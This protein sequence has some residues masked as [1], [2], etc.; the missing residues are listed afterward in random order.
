MRLVDTGFESQGFVFH[1]QLLPREW[2]QALLV[3]LATC[4]NLKPHGDR[5]LT[6]KVPLVAELCCDPSLLGGVQRYLQG[7][8]RLVR[9]LYFN[10]TP[11]TNWGIRWHQDK[12]IAL[13]HRCE[14]PG[15]G[16][17]SRKDGVDHVQP[18]L[19]VLERM[20]TLR[21]HLDATD[22]DQGCLQVIPGSHRDGILSPDAIATW[23]IRGPIQACDA[24]VGDGLLMRPHLLHA[25][26]RATIPSHRRI[27]HLEFSDYELPSGL[28]WH[29]D[30]E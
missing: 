16:P 21:L 15:W 11:Q 4:R 14:I 28:S 25:S 12:T 2:C 5:Q 27:I 20:V 6:R 1:R 10:K 29:E 22:R 24:G 9:S 26:S 23:K 19:D 17:W 8:P 18:S 30:L 3:A 13:S 7:P